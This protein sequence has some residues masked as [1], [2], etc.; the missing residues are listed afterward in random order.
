MAA[1]GKAPAIETYPSLA[2]D[3]EVQREAQA[4]TKN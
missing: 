4:L 3:E 1:F 2:Q